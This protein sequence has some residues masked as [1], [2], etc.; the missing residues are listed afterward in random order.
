MEGEALCAECHQ[1]VGG[2]Q[3]EHQRHR[4]RSHQGPCPHCLAA[5]PA[6]NGSAGT[7]ALLHPRVPTDLRQPARNPRPCATMAGATMAG[8]T[9]STRDSS[10][11]RSTMDSGHGAHSRWSRWPRQVTPVATPRSCKDKH[12]T[13]RQ[14]RDSGTW[15]CDATP[16]SSVRPRGHIPGGRRCASAG[17]DTRRWDGEPRRRWCRNARWWPCARGVAVTSAAL[18]SQ[19]RRVWTRGPWLYRRAVP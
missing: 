12:S 14:Q 6:P 11:G 1:G 19:H 10:A 2:E 7:H 15:R 18:R 17:G 16:L 5:A 9:A 3:Q 13:R 4:H 8:A